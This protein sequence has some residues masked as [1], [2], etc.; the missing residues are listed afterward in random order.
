MGRPGPK[1]RTLED[2]TAE[3]NNPSRDTHRDDTFTHSDH[4]DWEPLPAIEDRPLDAS[5]TAWEQPDYLH[6]SS[7]GLSDP[8]PVAVP[9]PAYASPNRPTG[10]R[11]RRKIVARALAVGVMVAMIVLLVVTILAGPNS[12]LGH[13]MNVEWVAPSWVFFLFPVFFMIRL[14]SGG[15]RSRRNRW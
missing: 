3:G 5:W 15:C 6:A 11:P 9:A 12:S 4:S 1:R 8:A 7:P 13:T 14:L 10:A 2:M